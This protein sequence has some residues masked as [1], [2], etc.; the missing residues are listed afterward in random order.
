MDS[1]RQS[2]LNIIHCNEETGAA[3]H[4]NLRYDFGYTVLFRVN[5]VYTDRIFVRK[6]F[7]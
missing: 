4:T 3:K 7:M 6:F 5:I 1:S 2:F